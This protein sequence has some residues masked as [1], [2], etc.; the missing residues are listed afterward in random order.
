MGRN[1]FSSVSTS[2]N[3]LAQKMSPGTE[4]N[5]GYTTFFNNIKTTMEPGMAVAEEQMSS[6]AIDVSTNI[7]PS[8][9]NL[10]DGIPS[11]NSLRQ[12][13]S[14]TTPALNNAAKSFAPVAQS[15][16]QQMKTFTE[17][18]E[19]NQM[20][21]SFKKIAGDVFSNGTNISK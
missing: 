1:N 8:I 12:I 9:T 10:Q 20:T 21:N 4:L 16:S 17:S 13:A 7:M 2:T 15:I 11:A 6:I 14:D 19:M 18:G 3:Q 5:T